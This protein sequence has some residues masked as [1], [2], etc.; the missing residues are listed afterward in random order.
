MGLDFLRES[1]TRQGNL[2]P[3]AFVKGFGIFRIA[4]IPCAPEIL[5]FVGTDTWISQKENT[6][7]GC[8]TLV[9]LEM[10]GQIFRNLYFVQNV[11][12]ILTSQL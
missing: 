11:C 8:T 1:N 7:A 12:Q 6:A 3:K 4:C 2:G 10:L 9:S 5:P